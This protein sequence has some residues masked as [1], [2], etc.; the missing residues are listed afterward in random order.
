MR[1]SARGEPGR[2]WRVTRSYWRTNV[3]S[4]RYRRVLKGAASRWTVGTHPRGCV[5][6][7]FLVGWRHANDVPRDFPPCFFRLRFGLQQRT[8]GCV[9]RSVIHGRAQRDEHEREGAHG[10]RGRRRSRCARMHRLRGL[11]VVCL[12]EPVRTFVGARLEGWVCEYPGGLLD[13]LRADAKVDLSRLRAVPWRAESFSEASAG[14]AHAHRVSTCSS[15]TYPPTLCRDRR[16]SS[17]GTT[18]ERSATSR[19]R[20]SR[21]AG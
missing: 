8:S 9:S 1:R 12:H 13:V 14:E 10:P 16:R 11:S 3:R 15:T 5:A 7:R 21:R 18:L 20:G 4:E 17:R 19:C 2:S 6:S